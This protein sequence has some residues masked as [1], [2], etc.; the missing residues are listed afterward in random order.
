MRA[1]NEEL[2]TG[3]RAPASM[4]IR[5]PEVMPALLDTLRFVS[6]FVSDLR[7]DLQAL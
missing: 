2:C 7:C 5:L 3:Q 6:D 4:F 1:R